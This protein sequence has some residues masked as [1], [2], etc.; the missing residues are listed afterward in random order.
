[1]DAKYEAAKK[2]RKAAKKKM[3]EQY[4][5]KKEAFKQ[6]L[7]TLGAAPPENEEVNESNGDFVGARMPEAMNVE[8]QGMSATEQEAWAA[9]TQ[10]VRHGL[11]DDVGTA[12]EEIKTWL[13]AA[14]GWTKK[15]RGFWGKDCLARSEARPEPSVVSAS[16]SWLSSRLALNQREVVTAFP[17]VLGLSPDELE[18][19]LAIAP[20]ELQNAK[21]FR[22][23]VS[24]KPDLLGRQVDCTSPTS[25]PGGKCIGRCRRCWKKVKVA[26]LIQSIPSPLVA[27]S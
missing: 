3:K 14:F 2:E 19:A 5:T 22:H 16:L 17:E 20:P 11:K 25:N 24:K 9:T 6:R 15:S 4:K 27:V 8:H 18:S 10:T 26:D 7:T 12:D 23:A 21:V 1:V 13:M